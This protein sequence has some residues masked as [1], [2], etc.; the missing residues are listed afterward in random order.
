MKEQV[1][2]FL[3]ESKG[4]ALVVNYDNDQ[5]FVGH[6]VDNFN[7]KLG[8]YTEN[9]ITLH[10]GSDEAFLFAFTLNDIESVNETEYTLTIHYENGA[11][12]QLDV[13]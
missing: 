11:F 2:N 1:L 5:F 6:S 12:L 4:N 3:Q 13:V 9:Q 10:E 7:F 8:E